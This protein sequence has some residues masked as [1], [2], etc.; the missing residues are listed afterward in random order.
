MTLAI[1]SIP[2]TRFP[3]GRPAR[4]DA[5]R[6][7]RRAR[8]AGFLRGQSDLGSKVAC[9]E[10]P[11]SD[12]ADASSAGQGRLGLDRLSDQEPI[13]F[14]PAQRDRQEK[15]PLV[16]EPVSTPDQAGFRDMR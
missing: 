15:I 3:R 1:N 11:A 10:T 5:R 9:G 13:L 7:S 6:R 12:L 14:K 4:R 16:G 8:A 2:G